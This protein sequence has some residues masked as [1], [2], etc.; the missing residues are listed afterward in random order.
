VKDWSWSSACW[1]CSDGGG[2]DVLVVLRLL[3][4]CLVSFLWVV[5]ML[6]LFFPASMVDAECNDFLAEEPMN[7]RGDEDDLLLATVVVEVFQ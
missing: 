4:S 3:S 1:R 7:D 6:L 5:A 2:D